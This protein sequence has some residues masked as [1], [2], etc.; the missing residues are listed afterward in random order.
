MER[1]RMEE[2]KRVTEIIKKKQLRSTREKG[3]NKI[4]K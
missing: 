3:K 1:R 2:K 4:D